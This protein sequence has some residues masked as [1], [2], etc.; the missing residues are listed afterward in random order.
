MPG[1]VP[2]WRLPPAGGLLQVGQS[3]GPLMAGSRQ[4][5]IQ[6]S[7]MAG[8]ARW[9]AYLA[10]LVPLVPAGP[11]FAA[12]AVA[13]AVA[14]AT[15]PAGKAS[16]PVPAVPVPQLS[17]S[18]PPAARPLPDADDPSL[19]R[20]TLLAQFQTDAGNALAL[21]RDSFGKTDKETQHEVDLMRDRLAADRDSA[22]VLAEKGTIDTRLVQAEIDSLGPAPKTGETEPPALADK[23]RELEDKLGLAMLPVLRW[24][25][26]QARASALVSELDARSS[27]MTHKRLLAHGKSPLDPRLWSDAIV[28]S[29][30]VLAALAAKIG[31]A[32]KEIGV[33]G[34]VGLVLL[35]LALLTI[36]PW[37]F[38]RVW[39][40]V[41]GLIEARITA[42]VSVGRK[43]GLSLLVD[44]LSLVLFVVALVI[45]ITGASLSLAP[46]IGGGAVAEFA[47]S[48]FI[49]SLLLAV[50]QWL[51]R[52]VLLSPI[53]DLRLIRFMPDPARQSLNIVRL[54]GLVLTLEAVVELLEQSGRIG[55]AMV[56]LVSSMLVVAGSWLLWRLARLIGT[57]PREPREAV[58]AGQDDTRGRIDFATPISRVLAG[59]AVIATLTALAGYTMMASKIFSDVLL[60]L[61]VVAMGVYIHRSIKLVLRALAAGPLHRYRRVLH[62]VPMASGLV[63]VLVAALL[64]ALIWGYRVQEVSDAVAA[65]RTG[66]K[67]GN[68]NVS[69]SDAVKFAIVFGVGLMFTRWLQG[70]LRVAILPEFGMDAGVQS[71]LVTAIGYIG[72]LLAAIIAI[73]STGLDLSSLAFVAGALSVGIGFGLQ[74]V[75]E[76]FTSGILLLVERPVREGDWIVVGTNEGIV[77][78]I[79]VRS[80]RIETFD[81]HFIIV[82]NSQLISSAVKNMTFSGGVARVLVQVGVAYGSDYDKVRDV[83]MSIA[84]DDPRVVAQPAPMVWLTDFGDSS[85]NFRLACWISSAL[86][87]GSARSDLYFRVARRFADEG[88][89]I[90]FPQRDINIRSMPAPVMPATV[91]PATE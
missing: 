38:F 11:A 71:A 45:V 24:R 60:T 75:V 69:A 76:N 40:R 16:V 9:L 1:R 90:P 57:A 55:S 88:I 12:P 66:V 15:S 85:V 18:P 68:V 65:L 19:Q 91:M 83:L 48:L 84:E 56:N 86:T 29:G 26:A 80:T 2:Q 58:A 59:F 79:A 28:E 33:A 14:V 62:F 89:E 82:P 7:M 25:E 64:V 27:D 13:G 32:Q 72:T 35:A 37:F 44:A 41:R 4:E 63:L 47:S 3:W 34:V 36:P 49:A 54:V 61:A 6:R 70:F 21:L 74:S 46:V 67:F 17:P 77:R 50:A 30:Q 5:G 78:K 51:G 10:A 43:L 73:A 81:G 42:S 23:R 31:A 53:H 22:Q 8:M 39:T 52:S 20:D 87:S